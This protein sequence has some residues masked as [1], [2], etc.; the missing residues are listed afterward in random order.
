LTAAIEV[1]AAR[2]E[3]SQIQAREMAGLRSDMES[4]KTVDLAKGLL[5][6]HGRTEE[7]AYREIQNKARS[8][9]VSIRLA[10]NEVLHE[11]AQ[12]A[13]RTANDLSK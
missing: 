2:F 4:R 11:A 12:E 6:A 9:R 10:A 5:M 3:D 7:E 1:A 13:L 8:K